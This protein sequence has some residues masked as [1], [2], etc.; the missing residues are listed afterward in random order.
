MPRVLFKDLMLHGKAQDGLST[1]RGKR[2]EI[3][4]VCVCV[5]QQAKRLRC[6][7]FLEGNAGAGG[8]GGL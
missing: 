8:T 2:G 6:V 3:S 5:G 4:C 1:C 7:M